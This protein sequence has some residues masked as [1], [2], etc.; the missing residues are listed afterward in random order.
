MTIPP[1]APPPQAPRKR[2]TW[3]IVVVV[4]AALVAAFCGF[5]VVRFAINIMDVAGT[6]N[7]VKELT[8]T[9]I[10]DANGG[11]GSAGYDDLCAEAKEE[12]RE[13]DLAKPQPVKDYRITGTDIEWARGQA[14]VTVEVTHPDG[15]SSIERYILDEDDRETWHM[16]E[17]PNL[18]A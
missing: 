17:F 14:T 8:A 18:T 10:D 16:C 5:G 12:F 7:D 1:Q 11:L 6:E 3:V 9:F 2:K 13:Q 4:V 15:K